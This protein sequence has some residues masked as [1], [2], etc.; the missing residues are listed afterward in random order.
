MTLSLNYM[1]NDLNGQLHP[2]FNIQNN[3]NGRDCRHSQG[4]LLYE[5]MSIF[6][7]FFNELSDI[8]PVSQQVMLH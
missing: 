3:V 7:F 8:Q 5:D 2:S 1:S 4:L 6:F